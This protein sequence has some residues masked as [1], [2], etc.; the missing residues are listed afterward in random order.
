MRLLQRMIVCMTAIAFLWLG[1]L[2]WFAKQIPA[3][4]PKGDL[5]AEAIV[6]LTGGP[7][8]IT[9][10]LK[11][12]AEER[13][14][15]LFISGMETPTTPKALVHTTGLTDQVVDPESAITLGFVARNTIGN[16]LETAEW[17]HKRHIH[18]MLLV[19][20]SY[21]MPRALS[22]FH[23]QLPAIAII[24]HPVISTYSGAMLL[25]EYHKYLAAELRHSFIDW[26]GKSA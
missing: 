12:L 14:P 22:E 15:Y 19:T 16:A 2:Y 26:L 25:E 4:M 6:V 20:S 3:H 7:G 18:S 10:G 8:R 21:H 17:V 9:H 24:P 13:A 23:Y 11:L 1:G 5:S